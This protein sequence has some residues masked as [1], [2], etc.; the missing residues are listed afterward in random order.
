M[1]ATE[2]RR[3]PTRFSRCLEVLPELSRDIGIGRYDGE[4]IIGAIGPATERPFGTFQRSCGLW[5]RSSS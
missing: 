1:P 2:P 5:N 3:P 4:A